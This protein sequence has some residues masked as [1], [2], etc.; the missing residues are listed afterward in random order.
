MTK[1]PKVLIHNDVT[2]AMA[3]RLSQVAPDVDMR[4]CHSNAELD[5]MIPKF[6]PDAVYSVRFDVSQPFPRDALLA[7]GGP[8]WISVGGSGC[9][10]LGDWDTSR[11]TVTNSAGVAASMMAE[12]VFGCA[13]HFTLDIQG[14]QRDKAARHWL[15][16]QVSPL[17]GKTLLIVGLGQT[18]QAVAAK[19]KAFGMAVLGTRARP[20]PVK[21]VDEVHAADSLPRLWPR[22]DLICVC[23]PRLPSTLGLIDAEAFSLM[24]R[25]AILVDVSRGGVI[26]P[27][28]AIA[29]MQNNRIAGAAF[30]VFETEP[31]PTDSPYW[32]LENTIISPH[33]SAVYDGWDLTS[34]D[35]FLDNLERWRRDE[36]LQNVVNP[37]RGY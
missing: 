4:T 15:L 17:R 9:D 30:D 18:G 19:A 31:L 24:K 35:M 27:D 8:R 20:Q 3:A 2:D 13:L 23:V 7:E 33:A 25:T 1:A 28:A 16:K 11:V 12:F 34:F 5:A 29:A 36:P 22:A 10:H 6:R 26:D 21:N 37:A 14:L 32:D